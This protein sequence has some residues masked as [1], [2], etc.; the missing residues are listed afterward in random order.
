MRPDHVKNRMNRNDAKQ[1]QRIT[2]HDVLD[3]YEHDLRHKRCVGN[4]H[5]HGSSCQTYKKH[6]Q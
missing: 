6:V 2:H 5:D 3:G 1:I 4:S